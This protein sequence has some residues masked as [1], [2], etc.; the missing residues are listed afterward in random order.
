[1][2]ERPTSNYEKHVRMPRMELFGLATIAEAE[3]LEGEI[4]WVLSS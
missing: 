3:A 1:L 4:M 2:T